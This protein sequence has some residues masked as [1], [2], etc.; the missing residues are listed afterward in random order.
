MNENFDNW[1]MNYMEGALSEE[2]LQKF[3]ALLKSD[4]YYQNRYKELAEMRAKLLVPHF[5]EQ[6]VDNYKELLHRLDLKKD[7]RSLAIS[8]QRFSWKGVRRVAATIALLVTSTIACYYLWNDI[9]QSTQDTVLCQMEVP[10]GS[11]TKVILPDGSVVCL[12]SGS[13]LRYDPA[14]AGKK[15][16]DVYLAGEGYFEVQKNEKKPFI[17]HTDHISVKVLGTVFNVRAYKEDPNV[18]VAL[19]KGRVNVFSKSETKGNVMLQPNQ[20]AVYDKHSKQLYSD[21]IDS[22]TIAQWTT[23]RLSFVNTSLEKILQN[24]ERKYNVRI[25]IQSKEMKSEIFSGSISSKLSLDE[26][27]DYLDVDNKYERTRKGN[28]ITIKDK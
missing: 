12:N 4:A 18:E 13:V 15:N 21:A 22:E 26:V 20:R 7:E 19:L 10:L 14:F 11:Q 24:V 5:A 1:M 2:D 28:V 17:V 6:E 16:R 3:H 27:L 25:D 9:R 8:S 23:G